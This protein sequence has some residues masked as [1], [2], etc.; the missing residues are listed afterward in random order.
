MYKKNQEWA[1]QKEKF[2][3]ELRNGKQVSEER[4]M[5]ECTFL[6]N[7]EVRLVHPGSESDLAG[8]ARGRELRAHQ[9]G[10]HTKVSEKVQQGQD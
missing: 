9:H 7:R 1:E 6:P 10:L 2:L 5:Q 8:A 3:D 4:N